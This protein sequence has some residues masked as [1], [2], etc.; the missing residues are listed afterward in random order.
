[1]ASIYPRGR[2]LWCAYKDAAGKRC[3]V[4]T[5]YAVGQEGLANRFADELE[6]QSTRAAE[7]APDGPLTVERYAQVWARARKARGVS[8]ADA[9]LSR[10]EKHAFPSIGTLRLAEVRTRHVRDVVHA[11]KARCGQGETDLAPRSVR[12]V[13]ATLH[14]LFAEA[15]V[16]ELVTSNP[17]VFKRGDLPKKIDKDP[18]WRAGAIFTR[19]EV[20]SLISA[21]SVPLDRRMFYALMFFTGCRFGEVSALRWSAYDTTR[22]PLGHLLVTTS[23]NSKSKKEKSTKTEQVRQVPV[24]PVLAKLLAEWKLSGWRQFFDKPAG[25]NDLI[26]PSRT[27]ENRKSSHSW[28]KFAQDLDQ[29]GLRRRRMHDARR[30]FI[31]LGLYD[32]ARRDILEAITHGPRGDIMSVYTTLPWDLL[33][34]E[35][36]KLKLEVRKGQVIRLPMA[37][38]ATGG[39]GDC[40]NDSATELLQSAQAGENNE[41]SKWRWRESKANVE[42]NDAETSGNLAEIST[43]RFD[44]TGNKST[45][46]TADCSTVAADSIA[47]RLAAMQRLW[48]ENPDNKKLLHLARSLVWALN[49]GGK[50]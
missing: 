33:C 14:M 42:G 24:H 16:D 2:K 22:K 19:E 37:A 49:R 5:P 41:E 9:D 36:T 10:L 46:S 20:E 44:A 29:L 8:T 40:S 50:S 28:Q 48:A 12:H 32:G 43:L 4:A 35:L 39:G 7:I 18:S 23:F 26:V 1:M 3:C 6:R 47:E 17:C 38:T 31:T 11:L 30:T 27:M 13:A 34:T 25:S 15:L 21:E 45:E